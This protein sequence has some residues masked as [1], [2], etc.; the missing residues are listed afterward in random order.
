MIYLCRSSVEPGIPRRS[1]LER[2][3]K[4]KKKSV[5]DPHQ[6][7]SWAASQLPR[8]SWWMKKIESSGQLLAN[9]FLVAVCSGEVKCCFRLTCR[10]CSLF[11]NRFYSKRNVYLYIYIYKIHRELS[12]PRKLEPKPNGINKGYPALWQPAPPS[13]EELACYWRPDLNHQHGTICGFGSVLLQFDD[14]SFIFQG[15]ILRQ[16]A[17]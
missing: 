6:P 5:R 7:I 9:T 10:V 4:L 14:W 15:E 12:N 11:T 2:C 13:K 17:T 8:R 1:P 16:L 3:F